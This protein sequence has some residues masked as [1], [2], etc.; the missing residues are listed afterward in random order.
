MKKHWRGQ[1]CSRF[2][3]RRHP[4]DNTLCGSDFRDIAGPVDND[5]EDLWGSPGGVEINNSDADVGRSGSPQV[6][7]QR[8]HGILQRLHR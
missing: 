2:P 3:H 8:V 4:I 5:I 7:E 6:I 1:T